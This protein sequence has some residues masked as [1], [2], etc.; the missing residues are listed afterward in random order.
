MPTK[1]EAELVWGVEGVGHADDEGTVLAGGDQGEHDPL[2]ES[3]RL[4]LLHLD[5]LLVQAFHGV[6]LAR[7][8]LAAAVDLAEAAAADDPVHGEVVHRQ[9]QV[10]L[11]VLPLAKP[12]ELFAVDE[13]LENAA[14]QVGENLLHVRLK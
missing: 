8:G 5:P 11:Q 4:P 12:R 3:Q 13:F 14:P 9:L 1:N 7:V 2:V 6:H 10:Q